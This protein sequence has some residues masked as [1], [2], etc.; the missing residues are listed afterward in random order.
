MDFEF[1]L[2]ENKELKN[3]IP[4]DHLQDI[5]SFDYRRLE[6]LRYIKLIIKKLFDWEEF[7]RWRTTDL[8][9]KI[10]EEKIDIVL[11][12]R[13]LKELYYEQEEELDFPLLSSELSLVFESL[14]DNYP[15]ATEYHLWEPTA[16]QKE[17]AAVENYKTHFFEMAT[18]ELN[19][20]LAE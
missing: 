14:L 2:E 11:A 16:L 5:N 18:A 8:L 20:L 1:W 7:E 3:E 17:L 6:S 9:Q 15:D 19:E 4:F 12:S 10:L 13:I